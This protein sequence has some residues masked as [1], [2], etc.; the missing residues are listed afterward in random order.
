MATSFEQIANQRKLV[1]DALFDT[2]IGSGTAKQLF[3]LRDAFDKTLSPE[4]GCKHQKI[5]SGKRSA[6]TVKRYRQTADTAFR[7]IVRG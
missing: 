3:R 6:E 7:P 5:G 4:Y 1:S 2:E